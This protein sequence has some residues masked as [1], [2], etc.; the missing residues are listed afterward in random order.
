[1]AHQ[2]SYITGCSAV[3]LVDQKNKVIGGLDIFAA[4]EGEAQ[5]H[6]AISVF[7]FN[8]KGEILLQQRSKRKIVAEMQ[9]ANACCANVGYGETFEQCAYRR[10]KEELGIS[11]VTLQELFTFEYHEKINQRF[12][13]WEIDRV[14][15]GF[16]EG[17]ISPNSNEVVGI[18][19]IKPEKLFQE[20]KIHPEKF[21]IWIKLLLKQ[22]KLSHFLATLS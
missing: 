8:S 15:T 9:W 3:T 16:Y 12:S 2:D 20:M 6:Q 11:D 7:L 10:L 22:Q 4:H 19:W 17:Q 5:K 1:M 14:F 21:S 13:E 18:R